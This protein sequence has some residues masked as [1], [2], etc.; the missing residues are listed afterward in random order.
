M[1]DM[2]REPLKLPVEYALIS[3]KALQKNLLPFYKFPGESIVIL[4][5]Q[6]FHDTYLI[7]NQSANFILRIYK[8]GWKTFEQVN[9]EL[10]LLL[11]LKTKGIAISYPLEDENRDLI[12]KIQSPEGE[13]FAVI[14]SYASGQ[15]VSSLNL[16]QATV[17]GKQLAEIHLV[18]ANRKIQNLH[19]LYTVDNILESTLSSI[20][21]VLSDNRNAYE[22][23]E[24]VC[25]VLKNK[26][27][28]SALSNL[29]AGICHGDPH[30]ENVFI[31]PS[32]NKLTFFDFDF[33]GNGFLLYDLGCFS[34]YERNNQENIKAFL[35]GYESVVTLNKT[36]RE[37]LPEF[38]V[39]MRLFHLGARSRNADGVKNPLWFPEEIAKKIDEIEKDV[40]L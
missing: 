1:D 18:T 13:R 35:E 23:L 25:M 36:E 2:V 21:I 39:L 33:S 24:G 29:R 30:H 32:S 6:G 34:Y 26:L 40:Q 15:M 7:K 3:S 14:F 16:D 10:D 17:F 11:L 38:R 8:S 22:K 20:R 12:H 27:P 37:L 28:E 31:E 5:H 9:A 4:I 19:R